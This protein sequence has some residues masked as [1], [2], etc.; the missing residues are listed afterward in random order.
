MIAGAKAL[1]K[2]G[3]DLRRTLWG[4]IVQLGNGYYHAAWDDQPHERDMLDAGYQSRAKAICRIAQR[5]LRRVDV[6][7]IVTAKELR[8]RI[9]R[10]TLEP[11]ASEW[12]IELEREP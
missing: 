3:A 9:V 6:G 8:W 11:L 10:V 2:R 1:A 12:R 7:E 5:E 4:V